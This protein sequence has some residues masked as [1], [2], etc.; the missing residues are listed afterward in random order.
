MYF[1]YSFFKIQI[2]LKNENNKKVKFLWIFIVNTKYLKCLIFL[3][4]E[5]LISNTILFLII[6]DGYLS[7]NNLNIE[8]SLS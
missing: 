5:I 2:V 7:Y 4:N 6:K 1:L 8:Y 3:L